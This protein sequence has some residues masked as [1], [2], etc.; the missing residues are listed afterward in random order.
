[1][2]VHYHRI[3]NGIISMNRGAGMLRA[4]LPPQH[5]HLPPLIEKIRKRNALNQ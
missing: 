2:M 3:E 5:P 4:A 1:M